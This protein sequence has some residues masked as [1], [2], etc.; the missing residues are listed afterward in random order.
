M[1]TFNV[2]TRE[3]VSAAN[4]EI[5]DKLAKGLGKVPNLYA[6][7][8]Y[9]EN[10]LATYLALS[11]AKT[12]FKA[13]EK[14]AINL[15]VSQVNE[16]LYCLSAHTMIGKMNGFTDEQILQIRRGEVSFDSK[17]DALVKLAQDLTAKRGH[18]DAALLDNFYAA[19]YTNENLVD[20]IVVIGDK[21]ITNLLY[22]ATEIPV[23]FPAVPALE[24]AHA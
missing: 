17:L 10:G 4:Q 21:T 1:K 22:A 3:T 11:N 5:F 9:S 6:T 18:G 23:D 2:P 12:S 8:A 19:G 24:T 14:E 7:M 16:C 13:K 15:I 20:L